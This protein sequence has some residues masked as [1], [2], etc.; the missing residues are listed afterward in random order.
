M[1]VHYLQHAPFE[2]IGSIE[3]WLARRGAEVSATRL[4]AGD[5]P[6]D[7]GSLASADLLVVMGGPVSANDESAFPWLAPEKAAIRDAVRSGMPVLGICLGAQLIASSLGARVYPNPVKEIGWFPIRGRG[8]AS[9]VFQF[10]ART[11]VFHWHGE[12][13]TLPE[14]A[15]LI[16]STESCRNQAFQIGRRVMGLQFHLEVTASQVRQMVEHGQGD[17]VPGPCVQSEAQLLAAP[18][19][20]YERINAMMDE[21][22]EYLTGPPSR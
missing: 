22:M 8:G 3:G 1:K 10:P 2:G 21:V 16:A 9:S 13:F 18:A 6:P 11:S 17:L 4:Y 19:Q 5:A 7:V 15:T 12:T 20:D 14:D